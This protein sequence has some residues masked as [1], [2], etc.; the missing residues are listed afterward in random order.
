MKLLVKL[1]ENQI[2]ALDATMNTF[3]YSMPPY[4]KRRIRPIALEFGVADNFFLSDTARVALAIKVYFKHCGE[5]FC[6]FSD[7]ERP[8]IKSLVAYRLRAAG[9]QYC[10]HVECWEIPDEAENQQPYSYTD[11]RDNGLPPTA[12]KVGIPRPH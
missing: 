8:D 5:S 12:V 6:Y 3:E 11:I 7:Y 2:K 4:L 1:T 10:K 9:L